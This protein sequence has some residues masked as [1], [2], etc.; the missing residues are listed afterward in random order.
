[1]M[2]DHC[3][4]CGKIIK[5]NHFH[6]AGDIYHP[7]CAEAMGII[8]CDICGTVYDNTHETHDCNEEN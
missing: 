7:E 2:P 3:S 8:T 1:M 5:E 4:M 6:Y